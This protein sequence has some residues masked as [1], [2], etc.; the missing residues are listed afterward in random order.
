M[1]GFLEKGFLFIFFI[2][3]QYSIFILL[4]KSNNLYR[5]RERVGSHGY[6][7]MAAR[8]KRACMNHE[9]MYGLMIWQKEENLKIENW[10]IIVGYP[11]LTIYISRKPITWVA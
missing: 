1:D 5:V 9:T 4:I 11:Y 10:K 2:F 3:C 8:A 7:V 6:A